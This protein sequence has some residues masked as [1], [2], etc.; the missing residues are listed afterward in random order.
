MAKWMAALAVLA[1]TAC[2]ISTEP[3]PPPKPASSE[4]FTLQIIADE[5]SQVYYVAHADGRAAAARAAGG[6]STLI[7]PSEAEAAAEARLGVM[8]EPSDGPVHIRFPGVSISV[9]EQ[10]GTGADRARVAINVAGHEILVDAQDHGDDKED[11]VVRIPGVSA[12]AARDFIDD[13]E[14]LSADVKAQMKEALGL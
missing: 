9:A 3:G 13:A 4:G 7:D 14:R 8:G 5:N 2:S 6:E 11:A 12:E 1:L 10:D